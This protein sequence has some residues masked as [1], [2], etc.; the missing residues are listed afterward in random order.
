MKAK[1]LKQV[2]PAKPRTGRPPDYSGDRGGLVRILEK[3]AIERGI[4]PADIS[5][6]TG[7]SSSH[8]SNVRKGK[9]A[10]GSSLDA[11]AQAVGLDLND[12]TL[13]SRLWQELQDLLID[14]LS[15]PENEN[16]EK[17]LFLDDLVR[18]LEKDVP[19]RTQLIFDFLEGINPRSK[20]PVYV[21]GDPRD[22]PPVGSNPAL[23][24]ARR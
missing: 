2:A 4:Q 12:E 10:I 9:A 7:I 18:S 8:L 21:L 22:F 11:W 20:R 23:Y 16:R 3:V 6:A 5:D 13:V 15:D 19:V 17:I 24:K 14:R 1:P